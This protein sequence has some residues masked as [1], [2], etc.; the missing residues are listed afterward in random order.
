MLTPGVSIRRVSRSSH[1]EP[2]ETAT[3]I[4]RLAQKVAFA[5][6]NLTCSSALA[7][8]SP[9]FS[10]ACEHEVLLIGA[11]SA[12][13]TTTCGRTMCAVLMLDIDR[14]AAARAGTCC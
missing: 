2:A 10:T 13:L 11:P 14:T 8:L 12:G 4:N 9:A 7:P 3:C 5:Y 1:E 6:W